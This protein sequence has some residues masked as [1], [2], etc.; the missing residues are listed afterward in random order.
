MT[1]NTSL[2]RYSA[3]LLATAASNMIAGCNSIDAANTSAESVTQKWAVLCAAGISSN[4]LTKEDIG[5][6]LCSFYKDCD[7]P[8]N[9]P[10]AARS[11]YFAIS[12]VITN[13]ATDRL[14]AGEALFTVARSFK[15][16][17]QQAKKSGGKGRGGKD[18]AS[19]AQL[20]TFN[21]AA[22]A[23]V[24]W[25]NTASANTAAAVELS[26]NSMIAEVMAALGKL[27][28]AAAVGATKQ[29]AET[30]KRQAAKLQVIADAKALAASKAKPKKVA[31]ATPKNH[32]RGKS[33]ISVKMLQAA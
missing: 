32:P 15:A 27:Q 24:H 11:R 12:K 21:D 5:K 30:A 22:A 19:K 17:Q 2:I 29:K 25:C 23:M 33:R 9:L 6:G 13:N 26:N 20:V 31:A 4:S 8:S 28:I 7:K 1:K 18:I 3:K 16:T 10:S 14:L